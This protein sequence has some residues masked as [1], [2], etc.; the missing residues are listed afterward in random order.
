MYVKGGVDTGKVFWSGGE[1]AKNAAETWAK[2]NNAT[3]LEM[4]SRGIELTNL[5]KDMPWSQAK[6]M[7]QDT[8]RSFAQQATGEVNVFHNSAGV[9][10]ESIWAKD[11]YVEL[12]KNQNIT[13]IN[14]HVV[15]PDGKITTINQNG[16]VLS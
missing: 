9:N 2:A 14:Y 11:E 1:Q 16:G 6:P 12:M 7:W 5:T 15:M 3:T 13:Q 4:T 8:S 10:I